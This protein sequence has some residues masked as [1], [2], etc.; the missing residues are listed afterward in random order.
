MPCCKRNGATFAARTD[1][2]ERMSMWSTDLGTL[3]EQ[4]ACS[5]TF[6]PALSASACLLLASDGGKS[7]R[8][9]TH[10]ERI[11]AIAGPAQDLSARQA[12]A[13]H[14]SGHRQF[15]CALDLQ[16]AGSD[17]AKRGDPVRSGTPPAVILPPAFQVPSLA[18]PGSPQLPMHL[19]ALCPS[20]PPLNSDRHPLSLLL[21]PPYEKPSVLTAYFQPP[22]A[23]LVGKQSTTWRWKSSPLTSLNGVLGLLNL[24]RCVPREHICVFLSSS[25]EQ[26]D[27]MLSRANQG[28]LSTTITVDQLWDKH[29]MSW[30]EVRRLEVELGAIVI[31]PTPGACLPRHRKCSPGRSCEPCESVVSSSRRRILSSFLG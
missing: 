5:P 23:R 31:I 18:Q 8:S 1:S 20:E 4:V 2:C 3:S 30:I 14:R 19:H 29:C 16:Q 12:A 25:T 21:P 9:W 6:H 17:L 7:I 11:T 15:P 13:R 28:L 26:M 10:G 27:A 22:N 24:Y